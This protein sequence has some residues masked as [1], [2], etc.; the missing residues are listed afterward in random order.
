MHLV[1]HVAKEHLVDE[2]ALIVQSTSTPNSDREGKHTS[3]A[4]SESMLDEF[5]YL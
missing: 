2:E 3:F 1:R 5:L 4:F